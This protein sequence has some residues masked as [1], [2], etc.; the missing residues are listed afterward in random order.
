MSIALKSLAALCFAWFAFYM[1][2]SIRSARWAAS[3]HS[4]E[5]LF[6]EFAPWRARGK[7]ETARTVLL[8]RMGLSVLLSL[9]LGLVSLIAAAILS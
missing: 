4:G 5:L 3:R 7:R 9:P 1:A 2:F 8:R 6:L